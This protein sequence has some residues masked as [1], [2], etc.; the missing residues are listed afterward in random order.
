MP[1]HGHA[2]DKSGCGACCGPIV[3][4]RALLGVA[5]V[6]VRW[7]ALPRA[8][9]QAARVLFVTG[10]PSARPEPASPDPTPRRAPPRVTRAPAPRS[11]RG[12]HPAEE[13]P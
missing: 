12:A 6:A 8:T 2:V 10:A 11:P 4:Q 1:C 7:S 5:P 13:T 3:V 9:A